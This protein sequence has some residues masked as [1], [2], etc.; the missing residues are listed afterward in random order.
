MYFTPTLHSI[1]LHPRREFH[2]WNPKSEKFASLSN[3]TSAVLW[4][5]QVNSLVIDRTFSFSG[6]RI[7]HVYY[8]ELCRDKDYMTMPIVASPAVMTLVRNNAFELMPYRD[9]RE[10][11]ATP[12]T[13]NTSRPTVTA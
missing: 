6:G 2:H 13:N 12:R 8:F 4:G 1:H 3:L 5:W 7:T 10:A 11:F 9:M